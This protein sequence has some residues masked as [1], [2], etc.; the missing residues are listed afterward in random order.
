MLVSLLFIGSSAN[1]NNEPQKSTVIHNPEAKENPN[2][3]QKY[4]F[5]IHI[6]NFFTRD[7]NGNILKY[8]NNLGRNKNTN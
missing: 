5:S 2:S 7:E 3:V 4:Y 6:Y 1:I 8:K